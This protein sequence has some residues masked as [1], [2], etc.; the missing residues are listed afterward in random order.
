MNSVSE[1]KSKI[2]DLEKQVLELREENKR[3]LECQKENWMMESMNDMRDSNKKLE[4]KCNKLKD[5][6]LDTQTEMYSRVTREN[7]N[8]VRSE[9]L[10]LKKK[11]LGL[12]SILITFR[13]NIQKDSNLDVTSRYSYKVI[14][15]FIISMLG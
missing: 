10:E 4:E 11:Q 1:L 9:L 14:L 15:N 8:R 5:S 3:L 12:G 13:E 7:H 2:S 6:L